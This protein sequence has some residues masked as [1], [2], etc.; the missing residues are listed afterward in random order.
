MK[1]VKRIPLSDSFSTSRQRQTK[2]CRT[3]GYDKLKFVGQLG[4]DKL[5]LA[6]GR[7]Y[8]PGKVSMIDS[9]LVLPFFPWGQ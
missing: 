1:I 3:P 2:V 5:K 9:L 4:N 6:P 7:W 8:D